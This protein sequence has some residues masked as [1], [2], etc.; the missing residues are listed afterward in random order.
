MIISKRTIFSPFFVVIALFGSLLA[1]V[2]GASNAMANQRRDYTRAEYIEMYKHIAIDH[3][4][5]YGIP[6]SIT[7]AQGILESNNGNSILSR[8][9][10][11][12]FGIK[13]KSH[14]T[15][16]TFTHTDDEPDECFRAYDSVEE[17]YADHAEFL[18]SSPRYDS[19]FN[20]APTDYKS[21][22]RALKNAGYATSPT[23]TQTLIKLIED[24]KLYLLDTAGPA[25]GNVA[26]QNLLQ[27]S[28]NTDERRYAGNAVVDPNDFRV[29]IKSHNGYDVYRANRTY[30]VLAKAGDTYSSIAKKFGLTTN[31]ILRFNDVEDKAA[32][33]TEYDVVYVERKQSE[34]GGS[35]IFH[36]VQK[37]ET[38]HDI[39]QSYGIRE[40]VLRRLNQLSKGD[41]IDEGRCINLK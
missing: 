8:G 36:I 40:S 16:R 38:L 33:L 1:S 3:Q 24:N 7:M 26:P 30:Y 32:E 22:A 28:Q 17:S 34:W 18:D 37:G 29:T 13:C 39:S 35:A 41:T 2:C 15:G 5:K 19:L 6:A 4:Q 9:S 21:W 14:W 12:H 10:N 31:H 23:Y 25:E 27:L 20:F 11:N